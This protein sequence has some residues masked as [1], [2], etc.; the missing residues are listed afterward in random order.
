MTSTQ[1]HVFDPARAA[2]HYRAAL[3]RIVET[4]FALTGLDET[5]VIATLPRCTRNYVLRILRPAESA[6]RRLIVVAARG[7]KVAV[8][9][10]SECGETPPHSVILG[11]DPR[12]H[13]G[14]SANPSKTKIS[15]SLS[16]AGGGRRLHGVGRRVK[17]E[18]DAR[19]EASQPTG[20]TAPSFPLL[21]SLKRFDFGPPRRYATTAPRVR[22]LGGPALPVYM[23]L[24]DLP[25]KPLPMPGDALDSTRL[26]ARM[27]ALKAALNDLDKQAKRL[28]RWQARRDLRRK[29]PDRKPGRI[30]PMRPGW[31]PGHRKRP[32][33]EVDDVLRECHSLA[34]RALKP[35]DT[36]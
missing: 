8:R 2:E 29:R 27:H 11:L 20:N 36:G 19:Y 23:R 16:I 24:P 28:A 13:S 3:L 18:D 34:V 32:V 7:I 10:A 5:A 6:A 1:R 17:P 25:E 26:C 12:T 22:S 31:P 15:A 14:D 21:D 35:P 4:L 30:S 9:V 33:H